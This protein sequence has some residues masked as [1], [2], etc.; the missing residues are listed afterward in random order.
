MGSGSEKKH[1]TFRRL[2]VD[3]V[4]V[5]SLIGST[6]WLSLTLSRGPGELAAVW[7]SNGILVGWLL[8]RS[9]SLWAWYLA[10][11]FAADLAAQLIAG[12]PPAYAMIIGASNII[13]V[14]V[15]AGWVRRLVP[16]LRDPKRWLGLGGIA[17][18]S[19]L[20]A[21][22]VSGLIVATTATLLKGGSFSAHLFTWYAAHVVGMVVFATF[23]LVVH[24]EGMAPVAAPGRRWGFAGATLL[25]LVVSVMV[26]NFKHEILFLTYPPLLLLAFRHGF[27]GVTVGV[28]LLGTVGGLATS[29]GHGPFWISPE[30]GESNR[31]ALLQLYIVGGCLMTIPVALV[32]AERERLTQRLRD[33]EHRYRMLADYSHDVV[34]RMRADGERIYASPSVRDML[35]WDPAEMLRSR[36]DLIHPDDRDR[37]ARAMDE[38][39]AA[40]KPTT[41]V[42]RIR[43]KSGHYVW[44]EIVAR[45]APSN[46]REGE[47][48]VIVSG[49]NVSSRVAAEQALEESKRE[50]ERLATTDALTGLPNRRQ[51]DARLSLALNRLQRYGSPVALM[52]LDVD[53]FKRINDGH[54]HVIGDAV[55]RE[56]AHRLANSVRAVDLVARLGGDEFAVLV[57]DAA[58]PE[59]AEAIAIKLI[60]AMRSEIASAGKTLK[61]TTSIGIAYAVAPV[62]AA[63]LMSTADAAL[64]EAKDDGRNTYS[65]KSPTSP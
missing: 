9:T 39:I 19:T 64:Y 65:V 16:R 54:G 15:V 26:F 22:A 47:T 32:M 36:W 23:T 52:Y 4:V 11:G 60:Q 50:L 17:S 13:E 29:S 3:L 49:R 56:F 55:L 21:C 42:Y 24:R 31:I 8:S 18:G 59:A 41:E 12:Q 40:G 27:A 43:H 51:F 57:E 63:T 10:A 28:I 44:V 58:V 7:I 2:C 35:G 45:P 46:D 1:P 6:G 5:G 25:L 53:H 33:S 30:L 61:I 14:L 37:Q 38:V 62:E 34:V 20:V 48:D